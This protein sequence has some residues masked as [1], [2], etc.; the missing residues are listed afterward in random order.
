MVA[1]LTHKKLILINVKLKEKIIYWKNFKRIFLR[2][3]QFNNFELEIHGCNSRI[4]NK[5]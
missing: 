2:K 1:P 3:I 4:S 5:N